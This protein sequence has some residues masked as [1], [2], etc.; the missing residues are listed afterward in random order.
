MCIHSN[1]VHGH[2]R[3][4]YFPETNISVGHDSLCRYKNFKRLFEIRSIRSVDNGVLSKV[5]R[6]LNFHRVHS[7]NVTRSLPVAP[8]RRAGGF[9]SIKSV[10]V[11]HVCDDRTRSAVPARTARPRVR[12]FVAVVQVAGNVVAVAR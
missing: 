7:V 12:T 6:V 8:N 5:R 1:Y 9:S 4:K 2:Y 11:V 10:F 3:Q